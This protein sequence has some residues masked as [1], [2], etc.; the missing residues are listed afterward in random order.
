MIAVYLLTLGLSSALVGAF[1]HSLLADL[2]F[3]PTF[4]VSSRLALG[5]AAGYITAQLCFVTL[6]KALKPTRARKFLLAESVSHAAAL[7]LLPFLMQVP[8]AWPDPS[9][10]KAEP[11]IFLGAFVALHAALKL[12]SFY[13]A[14]YS[15][16][17]GRLPVLAWLGAAC[18]TALAA[19]L[20][21][22]QWFSGIESA[23]PVA[24]SMPGMYRS[25]D[26][27][28]EARPIPEGAMAHYDLP[29]YA[30]RGITLRWANPPDVAP[31]DWVERAFVTV[32][33]LGGETERHRAVVSLDEGTWGTMQVPAEDIPGDATRCTVSWTYRP[34]P[35]WMRLIGFTPVV[36]SNR[37]LLVSGPLLHQARQETTAPNFVIIGIDGLSPAHVSAWGYGRRT[38][39]M[40]DRFIH[41]SVAFSYGYSPTPEARAAYMSLLTGVNPLCHGYFAGKNGPLPPRCESIVKLFREQHYATAAFTEGEYRADLDFGSGF[42]DGFEWFDAGYAA[43]EAGSRSTVEKALAWMEE[44]RGVKFMLF[45][46]I[47]ELTDLKVRERYGVGFLDR[48]DAPKDINLYDAMLEY[49]DTVA[50]VLVQHIRDSELR[51]NTCV[52]VLAPYAMQ[53][54]KDGRRI[55]PDLSEGAVRVPMIYC[56]PGVPHEARTYAVGIEDVVPAI[57]RVAGVPLDAAVDG[58]SF[59]QGPVGKDPVSMVAKPFGLSVLSGN[60]RY[61]WWPGAGA[62]GPVPMPGAGT[63]ALFRVGTSIREVKI[64]GEEERLVAEL[65]ARLAEYV[66]SSYTWRGLSSAA[67]VSDVVSPTAEK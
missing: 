57:A 33:I 55:G 10:A 50:G 38:T 58:R 31:A 16:P 52:L 39:P 22:Q 1:V 17:S 27:Y 63:S 61:V 64:S 36:R 43:E 67:P 28:A 51:D 19:A 24:T 53:F 32:K 66:H 2:G 62:F 48:P 12:F 20:A 18:G 25:G 21:L 9:L 11:L 41:N 45:I 23:R 6:V 26:T 7:L 44:H 54:G 35:S 56:A 3:A 59:L 15:E 30:E 14:L 5:A 37:Q 47:G 4:E 42:E 60:L 29:L 65:Q 34:A 46:R 8:I 40:L 49:V 13:T